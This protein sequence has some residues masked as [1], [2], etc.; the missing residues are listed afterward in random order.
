MTL[1]GAFKYPLRQSTDNVSQLTKQNQFRYLSR[2]HCK[3]IF[4]ICKSG[5]IT[6]PQSFP[7]LVLIGTT[8]FLFP[9]LAV[10]KEGKK[11]RW[12]KLEENSFRGIN[13]SSSAGFQD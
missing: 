11:K 10:T 3:I 13:S 9:N 5:N 4:G 2:V 1:K 8:F 12:K 6:I 7:P